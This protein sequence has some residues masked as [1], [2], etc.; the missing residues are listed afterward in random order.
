MLLRADNIVIAC[1]GRPCHLPLPGCAA[2]CVT[3]DDLFSLRHPPGKTLVIGASYVALECAGFLRE[4]GYETH[5]M[6]RSEPLRGFDRQ[7]AQH[8]LDHLK[9]LGTVVLRGTP[10]RFESAEHGGVLVTWD[11]ADGGDVTQGAYDTVLLAIG[12]T[13]DIE[14]LGLAS[15]VV[16]YSASGKIP[17]VRDQTNVP[18]IYAIGDVSVAPHCEL[19]PVAAMAGRLLAK[20]LFGGGTE[21]MQYG[22]V[23]TAVFT[24]LEYAHVGPSEEDARA[25][26]A[27]V[28][29]YHAQIAPLEWAI[30][31]RDAA[32]CYAKAICVATDGASSARVVALHLCAPN[33]AE[34]MQGFAVA[35]QCGLTKTQL[36][37]A[38]GIHL[39]VAESL[40]ALH[41]TKS[42]GAPVRRMGC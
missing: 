35:I 19:T 9:S 38:I 5:V 24:P 16:S 28:E 34:I 8:V 10:S 14:A 25:T 31:D 29:V 37:S 21:H 30:P 27:N 4:L 39:T 26:Y 42:S 6:M 41:V 32:H 33:A 18:H 23:P 40:T 13:F 2:L 1:G 20:R 36:D 3:S 7:M 15:A 22:C 17:T 12:R 11:V